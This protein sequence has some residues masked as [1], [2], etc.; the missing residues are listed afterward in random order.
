MRTSRKFCQRWSKFDN[1]FFCLFFLVDE[2]K[3]DP[4]TAIN[5]ESMGWALISLPAKRHLN[6]VLLVGR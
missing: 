1:F 3:E 4:N 6:G 5:I 2:G